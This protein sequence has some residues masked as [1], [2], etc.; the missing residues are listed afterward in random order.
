MTY[1]DTYFFN[2]EVA[3]EVASQENRYG[4]FNHLLQ[5]CYYDGEKIE[6]DLPNLIHLPLE[7]LSVLA[8]ERSRLPIGLNFSGL[9]ASESAKKEMIEHFK[10]LL[11]A[12]Y[13]KRATLNKM[14]F[15]KSKNAKL[16]FNEPLRFYLLADKSTKVMQHISKNIAD[17]LELAGY[18]VF[19]DL[20]QGI[21]EL[22]CLKKF[23]D[24]N[25]HVTININSFNN[26]F[27]NED[28]FNFVWFQDSMPV[29]LN[30][31]KI[32][33]R[34]RDYVFSLV[35]DQDKLLKKKKIPFK[36]QSFCV[37]TRKYKRVKTIQRSKKIVFI[38][39]SYHQDIFYEGK[40]KKLL[41]Q[42]KKLF[43]NGATFNENLIAQLA[44]KYKID[45]FFLQS[46]L[47]PF[48]IR[49]FSLLLLCDLASESDYEIEVYGYGWER[50]ETINTFFKGP[51]E[52]GDDIVKVYNSA[53]YAF[54]PHQT[55]ILQ[56]RVLE[57]SAC[58]AIPIVYD[59]RENLT[60]ESYDE[61]LCFFKTKEE[62]LEL[63]NADT[64]PKKDFQR[65]LEVNSYKSFIE[66]IVHT[67]EEELENE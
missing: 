28:V 57:A 7:N 65:L 52:Y 19:F 45:S 11:R 5:I 15:E 9:R 30:D 20:Y 53:T 55:Y 58:G 31:V 40:N 56:Q 10:T 49:D 44:K 13:E 6:S 1:Q 48:V 22:A 3:L 36:R 12:V 67:I 50:Y 18:N 33:V 38:G 4:A 59:C 35:D 23:S 41:K 51:L 64:V 27:L 47:I 62:L 32:Q 25:P 63:L 21:E 60:E 34:K 66:K 37:N 24:F 14:Y 61:G 54:A 43:I 26:N 8:E 42:L 2:G 17:E 39:S 46:K 16:N 29:L